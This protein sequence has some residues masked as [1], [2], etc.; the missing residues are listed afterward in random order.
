[1]HPPHAAPSSTVTSSLLS[2]LSLSLRLRQV[3]FD[4]EEGVD[5]GGVRKEYFQVMMRELLDPNY[6][7]F[8]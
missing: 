4:G 3:V 5:A 1:M 8:R 2:I 6:G 7:M